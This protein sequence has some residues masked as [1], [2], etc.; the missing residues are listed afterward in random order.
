V[1]S[2]VINVVE[3]EGACVPLPPPPQDV[4]NTAITT[5]RIVS[6]VAFL[7]VEHIVGMLLPL[8][9]SDV[10]NSER[11]AP[12]EMVAK[13]GVADRILEQEKLHSQ[14]GFEIS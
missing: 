7:K 4:K 8:A 14:R 5:K 3:L 10:S 9:G 11:L 6:A 13:R 12:D 2:E 1:A